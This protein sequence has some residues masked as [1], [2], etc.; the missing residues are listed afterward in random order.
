MPGTERAL[1][2]SVLIVTASRVVGDAL[3]YILELRAGVLGVRLSETGCCDAADSAAL[4]PWVV[5]IDVAS[6]EGLEAV[7]R[8]RARYP[9]AALICF[10]CEGGMASCLERAD[11]SLRV[12]RLDEPIDALL[13]TL[14]A[15]PPAR[16]GSAVAPP[17][18]V[19]DTSPRS[20][21]HD[22]NALLSPRQR[23]VLVLVDRGL[24]NKQ[25][26]LRLGVSVA[27]AKNHIHQVL[28]KLQARTRGEAAARFRDSRADA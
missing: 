26:A 9:T 6:R 27:T 2:Q 17:R 24:S 25:I 3:R 15:R 18:W 19:C 10:S 23:E 8:I 5:L 21:P 4:P 16:P 1:G 22:A 7:R 13:Q 20:G 28:E 11:P 14:R 12:L